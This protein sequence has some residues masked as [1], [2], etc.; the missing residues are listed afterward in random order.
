MSTTTEPETASQAE[1]ELVWAGSGP[2]L[3]T[4]DR[5]D[6]LAKAEEMSK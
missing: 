6:T 2:D 4:M 5:A 1:T 3:E